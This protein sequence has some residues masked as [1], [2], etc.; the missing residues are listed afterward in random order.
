MNGEIECRIVIFLVFVLVEMCSLHVPVL[1]GQVSRLVFSRTSSPVVLDLTLGTGGYASTFL[2]HSSSCRVVGVD[3]DPAQLNT[4]AR[5]SAQFG[6]RFSAKVPQKWSD[7]ESVFPSESFDAVVADLG[8]CT[9]QLLDSG[10]GF[11]F[12][13]KESDLLDMRMSQDGPTAAQLLDTMTEQQ[14]VAMLA[15]LGQEPMQRAKAISSRIVELLFYCY[16]LFVFLHQ[17]FGE[18][19][20]QLHLLLV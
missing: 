17:S 11:S 13:G 7:L 16:F 2:Q 12:R 14:M 9:T 6:D 1:V 19:S 4:V 5:L 3:R 15:Q 10:R 8:L 18:T 20:R